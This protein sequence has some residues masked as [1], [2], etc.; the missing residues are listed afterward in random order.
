MVKGANYGADHA[1]FLL[2][3][4]AVGYSLPCE[5]KQTDAKT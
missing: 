5:G 4:Q 3:F 1:I 2:H